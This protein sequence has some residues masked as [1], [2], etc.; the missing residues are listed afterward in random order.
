MFEH[1]K[2]LFDGET[3]E[4]K[5]HGYG[6][7]HLEEYTYEGEFFMNTFHGKGKKTYKNGCVS[8]VEYSF[9]EKVSEIFNI[10]G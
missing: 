9:N 6:I 5:R 2:L 10:E 8:A 4:G 3:F 1:G 7:H